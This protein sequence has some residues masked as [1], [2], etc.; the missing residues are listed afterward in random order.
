MSLARLETRAGTDPVLAVENLTIEFR[1][2]KRT[3]TVVD[4]VSFTVGAGET[5]AIVGESGAGKSVTALAIMRLLPKRS[6]RIAS[7]RILVNGEDLALASDE[8]LYRVRGNDVSMIFQEPMTALN[9]VLTI[10]EQ[11]TEVLRHH[12]GV[13]RARARD[14]AAAM[15]ERVGFADTGALLSEF[16]HHLSGG[17]RQRVMIAI[18]MACEPKLLIADE[19]TTALDVTV[20]AQV[21]GVMRELAAAS[22]TAIVL[23]THNLGLVAELARRVLVMY[24]GQIVERA[25]VAEL[26]D[27]P[28]HPYTRGLLS[29]VPRL[30]EE[31]ARLSFIPGSVPAPGAYSPGCRFVA[32]CPDAMAVCRERPPDELDVDSSHGARCWLHAARGTT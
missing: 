14:N 28:A 18:A 32:R 25:P 23:I 31:R 19:P 6:A 7:G 30:D 12:K 15:L 21:L 2:A 26:F 13:S 4:D 20:Q 10:G 3:L 24:A 5:V 1:S 9:P 29:S 11:I 16:P 8:R 17:M 22:G 27:Q